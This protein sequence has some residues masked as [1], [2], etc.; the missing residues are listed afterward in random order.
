MRDNNTY[1]RYVGERYFDN[2]LAT[3]KEIQDKL[4]DFD[5]D[6]KEHEPNSGG[7]PL[8]SDGH[9]A[10]LDNTDT[11]TLVIGS[12]GSMK[13]RAF[14]LPTITSLGLAGENMV[15]SDPKG[16]IFNYTSGFLKN[17]GYKINVLNFRDFNKTDCWNPL[18]EAWIL[19]QKGDLGGA[20]L[21][22]NDI[23]N[24]FISE[25]KNQSRDAFWPMAARDF[26]SGCLSLLF[27]TAEKEDEVHISSLKPF[28][29]RTYASSSSPL[30]REF[31]DFV[32]EL[33][34]TSTVK[35]NLSSSV[36]NA[37][38]TK[39]GV[40]GYVSSNINQFIQSRDIDKVTAINTIDMH[41]YADPT[42]KIITYII[43]PDEKTT[44]HFFCSLFV[45]QLYEV[46]IKEASSLPGLKLGNRLNFILD[47]FANIPAISE[48]SS[49]ISAARSRNIR[50]F[51]VLQSN[52]Q[53]QR[54]YGVE[55]AQNIKTNCQTWCF[56]NS[57]ETPLIKEVMDYI[58]NDDSEQG[59]PLLSTGEISLLEKKFPHVDSIILMNRFRP[60]ISTLADISSYSC[61][62]K[63]GQ[64]IY[65]AV[66]KKL[67]D[68]KPV[69]FDFYKQIT[70]K[71]KKDSHFAGSIAKKEDPMLETM[72][73]S[74]EPDDDDDDDDFDDD[75][76]ER[77]FDN[78]RK[79]N[80]STSK[81]GK[82]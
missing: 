79:Q 48:M 63:D 40:L 55:E 66:E 20:K 51:L 28:I 15:V 58:G 75:E 11:H 81:K 2:R 10:S 71:M 1:M 64:P 44:F 21:L 82:K 56:L 29:I 59:K 42:K 33:P 49:M 76:F 19:Y 72:V 7:T 6:S 18:H 80:S 43:V 5:F 32:E 67:Q 52:A 60:F 54:K 77:I 30:A 8:I 13:T 57:K 47:E 9:I 12:T 41:E 22:I 38:V 61:I 37:D 70:A 45:K 36:L 46:L 78:L 65:P 24:I 50:F 62:F 35:L 27:Y 14:I 69:D 34:D 31:I 53:L 74:V 68:F 39:R 25:E 23:A 4:S 3:K 17:L 26:V 73:T 16:E